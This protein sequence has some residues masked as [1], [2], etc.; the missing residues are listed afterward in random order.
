MPIE[1]IIAADAHKVTELAVA[2]GLSFSVFA[3]T[4]AAAISYV[5][6]KIAELQS[7]RN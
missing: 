1:A 2:L 6:S 7:T 5:N 4:A 3:S